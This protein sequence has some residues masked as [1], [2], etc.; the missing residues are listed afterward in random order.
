MSSLANELLDDLDGLS[1]EEEGDDYESRNGFKLPELPA[2]ATLKRKRPDDNNGDSDVNMSDDDNEEDK[3]GGLVLGGGVKPADELDQADV[4]E[5]EL[6]AVQ[7]VRSVAK[8]EG[9]KR[10]TEILKVII[11]Y[12]LCRSN[13]MCLI[14]KDS[15]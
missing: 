4:D 14:L 11:T 6:G 9:S 7:D 2:S 15:S 12:S 10:M 1:G 5:M 3:G 13:H 8:L